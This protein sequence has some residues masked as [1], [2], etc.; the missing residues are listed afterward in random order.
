[1]IIMNESKNKSKIVVKDKEAT[2][3]PRQSSDSNSSKTVV[4]LGGKRWEYQGKT[5]TEN[6]LY[7]SVGILSRKL[8]TNHDQSPASK[9]RRSNRLLEEQMKSV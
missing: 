3:Q 5:Y 8:Y 9:A 6:Y 4:S 2:N 1:M 7:S